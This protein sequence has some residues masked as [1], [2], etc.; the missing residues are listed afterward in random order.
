[1]N[2][3]FNHFF[4]R[5]TIICWLFFPSIGFGKQIDCETIEDDATYQMERYYTHLYSARNNPENQN[6]RPYGDWYERGSYRSQC[7]AV[8]GNYNFNEMGK[9]IPQGYIESFPETNEQNQHFLTNC[10]IAYTALN[11]AN[12]LANVYNAFC[13]K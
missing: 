5:F 11:R 2:K 9:Y 13:K 6:R 7:S 4:L 3:H 10:I 8:F 1:M 12:S